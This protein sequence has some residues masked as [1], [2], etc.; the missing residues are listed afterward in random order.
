MRFLHLTRLT[1]AL[2]LAAGLAAVGA[3]PTRAADKTANHP[4]GISFRHPDDW[5]I[6]S[7]G[8]MMLL[9]P[10]DLATSANGALEIYYLQVA[11]RPT[12]LTRADDSR[13]AAALDAQW[14]RQFP[15][16]KR[17]G[18]PVGVATELGPGAALAW[19]GT[20]E[21]GEAVRARSFTVISQGFLFQLIGVG[22]QEKVAAREETLRAVFS[23]FEA[24]EPRH[25]AELVGLWRFE[26]T[27]SLISG[28]FTAATLDRIELQ[29]E[30]DGS[31]RFAET[32][33]VVGDPGDTGEKTES[34]GLQ[35]FAG[36]GILCL[37][38]GD[39]SFASMQYEVQTGSGGRV[40]TVRIDGGQPRTY[41]EIR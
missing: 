37:A 17:T 26:K 25:D 28:N 12:D 40:L 27:S 20:S 29:L 1:F 35:W 16:L 6:G 10:P 3:P 36:E 24:A 2:G 5:Q 39:G 33:R 4:L 38:V 31:G 15:F 23:S 9:V 30:P 7:A 18:E 41:A 22:L 14:G 21:T 32:T 19:K 8:G 11:A 34:F 13:V